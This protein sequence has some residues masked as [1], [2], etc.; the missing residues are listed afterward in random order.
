MFRLRAALKGL[1]AKLTCIA[2]CLAVA[3]CSSWFT[4]GVT[5]PSPVRGMRVVWRVDM[6]LIDEGQYSLVIKHG[7]RTYTRK[8]WFEWGSAQRVNFF[9]DGA[10]RLIVVGV[11]G[12]IVVNLSG[13]K[14][15]SE[16]QIDLKGFTAKYI[17]ELRFWGSINIGQTDKKY[18]LVFTSPLDAAECRIKTAYV[19]LLS[20]AMHSRGALWCS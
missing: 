10:D 13:P 1:M 8:L 7:D 3:G 6:G 4:Q 18:I 15:F 2:Y 19:S 16:N 17:K 12:E 5:V 20:T 9:V 11:G 14:L